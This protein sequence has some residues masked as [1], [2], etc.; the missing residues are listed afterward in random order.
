MGKG[1]RGKRTGLRFLELKLT[2]VNTLTTVHGLIK[3]QANSKW[4]NP[5]EGISAQAEV[6]E[7]VR[8]AGE[9]W[10]ELNKLYKK[11]ARKNKLK[12]TL[13]KLVLQSCL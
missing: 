6:R 12:F 4:T 10:D 3:E 7:C 13:E 11:E 1:K 8:K 9:E 2:I 5:K